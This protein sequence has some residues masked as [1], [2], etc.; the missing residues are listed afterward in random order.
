MAY[1]EY[2]IP[3]KDIWPFIC[4]K[5]EIGFAYWEDFNKHME[6]IHKRQRTLSDSLDPKKENIPRSYVR[7]GYRID[8]K[9]VNENV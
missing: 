4:E 6:F 7:Y 1:E 8:N 3:G 9:E 2:L 5:C